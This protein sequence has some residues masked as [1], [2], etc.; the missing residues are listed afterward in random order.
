LF[1]KFRHFLLADDIDET[2]VIFMTE[3]HSD[4]E[5]YAIKKLMIEHAVLAAG[6]PNS[7]PEYRTLPTYS[8]WFGKKMPMDM[9]V[10]VLTNALNFIFTYKLPLSIQDTASIK[11]IR[12]VIQ[13]KHYTRPFT[14]ARQYP[15]SCT[16]LYHV[17]RLIEH[18]NVPGLSDIKE[19]LIMDLK[20]EMNKK[21]SYFEKILLCNSLLRLGEKNVV[22]PVTP[23]NIKKE[24]RKFYFF[25]ANFLLSSRSKLAWKL[26]KYNWCQLKFHCEA[27]YYCLL[28][29]NQLLRKTN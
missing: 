14:I 1:S 25:T 20:E 13:K 28:L 11:F 7:L 4:S 22:Q 23:L 17:A 8:T 16:I 9:E 5:A 27:Y 24:T 29:E 12:E 18:H 3:S 15:N 2:A 6:I 21:H 19:E 10:C 26:A